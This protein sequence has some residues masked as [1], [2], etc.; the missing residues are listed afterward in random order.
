MARTIA[1]E[2]ARRIRLVLLDVDGVLTDN[3]VYI[4]AT[5]AGEPVELKRFHVR[6]GLGIKLL[7]WAGL[8][9]VLVSGRVSTGTALR[10]AELGIACHQDRGGYKLATVEQLLAERGL[11]WGEVAF[12]G[13]D[14]ADLVVLARVGLPVAVGDAV[15]EVKA[16]AGWVTDTAGGEGAVREF[17]EALLRARGEWAALLEDYRRVREGSP[18]VNAGRTAGN[19]QERGTET[20]SN[21]GVRG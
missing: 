17:A 3:G 5:E 9:V 12:V 6:D 7:T 19:A 20:G 2:L 14:L 1:P 11:G 15:A 4:G 21:R 13:D 16:L 8:E 18:G 10:A